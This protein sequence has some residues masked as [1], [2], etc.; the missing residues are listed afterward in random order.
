MQ[1]KKNLLLSTALSAFFVTLASSLS[2]Y[3][4]PHT[5]FRTMP[6]H[7]SAIAAAMTGLLFSVSTPLPSVAAESSLFPMTSR[8]PLSQL[9]DDDFFLSRDPMFLDPFS[10]DLSTATRRI[11]IGLIDNDKS[12][13][14][15]A[16]LP[17]VKKSDIV[18]EIKD[19]TILTI[20]AERKELKQS[21]RKEMGRSSTHEYS[22]KFFRSIVLPDDAEVDSEKISAEFVDGVLTLDIPKTTKSPSLSKTVKIK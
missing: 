5:T 4:N 22:S 11:S 7:Q 10:K 21:S 12:Y 6:L 17:G 8:V 9:F 1:L 18:I 13:S 20:S 3:A 2:R 16:D 15:T 19:G 14:F